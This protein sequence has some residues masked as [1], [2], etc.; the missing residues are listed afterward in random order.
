MRDPRELFIEH[1]PA[2]VPP[3]SVLVYAFTGFVDAG[4]GVRLTAQ[5]ILAT[6]EHRL[7]ATFDPDELLDYRARRPAM[8]Y[9]VDHFVS[10]DIPQVTLHEVIDAQGRPFLLLHG[11][12]P[13]YQWQ[14]FMAAV[15]L[16][17]D[18]YQV[19]MAVGLT[20][21]PWPVPHTR[22]LG[23]T[24][25]GSEPEILAGFTSQVG[26]IEVPGHV[27]AMLEFHL[28]QGSLPSMGI[29]AQVPHYLVQFEYPRA[30][31]TIIHGLEHVA[32]VRIPLGD[33]EETAAGADR[34][35]AA[36]VE[37]N[38]EIAV[39]ISALEEQY[40]QQGVRAGA[41]ASG[42]GDLADEPMPTGDEIAAQLEQF[43]SS[44]DDPNDP[45]KQVG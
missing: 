8:Q 27:P 39:V 18:R 32:A 4:H 5:H 7:V 17:I 3:G 25:H 24:L 13:D 36:Q 21:M 44:L 1:A 45:G 40:D 15:D 35:V 42:L 30:V 20:S 16:I 6:C 11:P 10:V 14:R 23:M 38:A 22:P 37:G 41:A 43:L 29:T 12:E 28:A 33:L 34:D 31:L 26:E 19:G 9:V 2:Q